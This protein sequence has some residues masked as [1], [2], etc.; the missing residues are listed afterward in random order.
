[1]MEQQT[2]EVRLP[3]GPVCEVR[4]GE[5]VTCILPVAN[6]AAWHELYGGHLGRVVLA[7]GDGEGM[8]GYVTWQ[9]GEEPEG[10]WPVLHPRSDV[11]DPA[12]EGE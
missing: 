3:E 7:G 10:Q 11:V 6:L 2:I 4:G 5:D 9:E 12:P 8:A 1:M